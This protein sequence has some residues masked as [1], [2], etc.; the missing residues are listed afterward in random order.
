[1]SLGKEVFHLLSRRVDGWQDGEDGLLAFENLLVQHIV[2]LIDVDKSRCA[3]DDADGID[4][5]KLMLAIVDGDAQMLGR[6]RG[7]DVD[8]IGYRGAGEQL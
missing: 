3:E 8:G 2:C 5:G 6:A 1:M 7:K 4:I